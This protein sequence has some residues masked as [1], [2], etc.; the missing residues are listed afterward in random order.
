MKSVRPLVAVLLVLF[1][2]GAATAESSAG[3]HLGHPQEWYKADEARRIADAVLSF[4]APRG[5]WPKN[6]DT[7]AAPYAGRPDDLAGTFDNG[8]TT[9]ELR[10]LARMAA[11]TGEDRYARA[12]LK[13]LDH[14]LEAQYDNGGWPQFYPPPDR[15]YHRHIT[16]N[17]GAMARLMYLVRDV[18]ED[19]TA[20]G[21]VDPPRRRR[22]RAAWDKGVECILNCQVRANGTLTVWCAQHDEKT[23]EPRPARAFEKASLSG[24]ESV[25]LVRILMS[26][27]SPTSRIVEA[28]DAA[29]AYFDAVKLTGIRVEDRPQPGTPHGF[30]QVIV[31]DPSA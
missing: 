17:D 14:V 25:E 15:G 20:Y 21:F 5:D 2:A 23:L 13:G 26:V 29:K 3:K 12:F 6:V 31:E 7:A 16:F 9:P 22:C 24:C 18:A 8:A 27:K 30:D 4:Q 10:Y 1:P 28:I 19:D 11:S